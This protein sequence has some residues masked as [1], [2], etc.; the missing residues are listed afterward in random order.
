MVRFAT[1]L[2]L[3]GFAIALL[4][5]LVLLSTQPDEAIRRQADVNLRQLR[6]IAAAIEREALNRLRSMTK[7]LTRAA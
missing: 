4:G 6:D 2:V 3:T 1:N 5:I 7:T